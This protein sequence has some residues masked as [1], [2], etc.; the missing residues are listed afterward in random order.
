MVIWSVQNVPPLQIIL[1][2]SFFF[3]QKCHFVGKLHPSKSV[4]KFALYSIHWNLSLSF[5][6]FLSKTKM[7][8]LNPSNDLA[9][10]HLLFFEEKKLCTSLN[11]CFWWCSKLVKRCRYL[12]NNSVEQ[13]AVN[14]A[15]S[16]FW[17]VSDVRFC[18]HFVMCKHV[19][20]PSSWEYKVLFLCIMHIEY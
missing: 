12:L 1:G 15:T 20:A 17:Q 10:L 14:S 18:I 11:P 16:S 7:P 9:C 3:F 2:F 13:E 4:W 5:L 19:N 6:F 8:L